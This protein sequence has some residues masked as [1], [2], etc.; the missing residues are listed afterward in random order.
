MRTGVEWNGKI[1]F[2]S[3]LR[4]TPQPK[5][6]GWKSKTIASRLVVDKSRRA[7]LDSG[8]KRVKRL[9]VHDGPE[10]SQIFVR[11]NG[12]AQAPEDGLHRYVVGQHFRLDLAYLFIAGNLDDTAK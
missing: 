5:R 2:V 9:E 8:R 12:K 1:L 10:R 4:L 7:F 11:A 6:D 3:N